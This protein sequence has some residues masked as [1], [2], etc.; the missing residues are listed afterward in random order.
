MSFESFISNVHQLMPADRIITDDVRCYAFGVDASCFALTPKAVLRINTEYEMSAVMRLSSAHQVALTFRGAGTSVAGQATG[1]P[2]LIQLTSAWSGHRIDPLAERLHL[3]PAVT[4]EQVKRLLAPY[5]RQLNLQ[6]MPADTATIGGLVA[7]GALSVLAARLVLADG[8]VIDSRDEK[9]VAEF[10]ISHAQQLAQLSD[11]RSK[12]LADTD[13][14][15]QLRLASEPCRSTGYNLRALLEHEDP[16][17]ILIQLIVGSEGTLGFISEVSIA[18][19]EQ[20]RHQAGV[21]AGFNSVSDYLATNPRLS[22][23][24]LAVR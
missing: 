9:S 14:T 4:F 21:V 19:V 22:G 2:V 15:E 24:R 12:I 7:S 11:L 8:S 3:Q 23:V 17:D 6:T 5:G 10:R 1:S 20:P 16:I 13:Q 18:T